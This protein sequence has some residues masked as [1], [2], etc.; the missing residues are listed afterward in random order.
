MNEGYSEWGYISEKLVSKV[1]EYFPNPNSFSEHI[2]PRVVIIGAGPAGLFA[3]LKLIEKGNLKPKIKTALSQL[4]N[5]INK[6]R[7]DSILE[8]VLIKK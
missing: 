6:W 4:I 3:A 2:I 8:E 1:E 7:K 5:I